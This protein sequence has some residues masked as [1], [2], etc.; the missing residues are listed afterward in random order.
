MLHDSF[1][2]TL[3]DQARNLLTWSVGVVAY[4]AMLMA[5]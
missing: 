1:L 4:V 2:K 5:V 3:R